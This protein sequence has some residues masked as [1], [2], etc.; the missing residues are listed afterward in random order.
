[1]AS[2][3]TR[4]RLGLAS[5]TFPLTLDKQVK[6]GLTDSLA[7]R[8]SYIWDFPRN[9]GHATLISVDGVELDLIM[10]PLGIA[11]QLD[12]MN[13]DKTPVNLPFGKIIIERVILDL[14]DSERR[15]A[16]RFMGEH[17]ELEI[18]ATQNWD[19]ESEANAAFV[20]G[21]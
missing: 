21:A 4:Q 12:F 10:N 5:E 19:E 6:P 13:T 1:M 11:K 15:A 7:C 8:F 3:E 14:V 17:G 16:V 9:M 20:K 2:L 18:L